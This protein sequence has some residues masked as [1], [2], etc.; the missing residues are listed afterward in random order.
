ML[1]HVTH[2]TRYAYSKRV[3]LEP[4][5]LRVRPRANGTQRLIR[6]DLQIEPK[7]LGAT[8]C[9]DL[10]GNS[11]VELWFEGLTSSLTIVAA[12]EVE[13]LRRNPFDFLVEPRCRRLPMLYPASEEERLRAY[14]AGANGRGAVF[15]L[16]NLTAREAGGETVPFLIQLAERIKKLCAWTLREEGDPLPPKETLERRTGSCRDL[17]VL[18]IAACRE[19]GIAARFV[20]G[21]HAGRQ[22]S[23]ERHLHAWAEAYVPGGG[24]RGFDPTHGL[25]VAEEHVAIAASADFRGAAPISGSLRGEEVSSTMRSEIDIRALQGEA[26]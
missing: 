20:T 24:W 16:A 7:P 25:A 9:L 22:E 12:M 19:Q 13:T 6:F 18:F 11:V 21:Y 2:A 26:Q 8:D 23:G 5:V 10:E 1:F 4:H 14:T 3:H 15:D 17:A